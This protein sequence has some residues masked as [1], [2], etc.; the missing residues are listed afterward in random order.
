MRHQCRSNI[1]PSKARLYRLETGLS[2]D[3]TPYR[4]HVGLVGADGALAERLEPRT[5]RRLPVM[6]VS[7]HGLGDF[8]LERDPR[9]GL[10]R[11]DAILLS[12][13]AGGRPRLEAG[14]PAASIACPPAPVATAGSGQGDGSGSCLLR[15]SGIASK[16]ALP[17][18][19]LSGCR[20]EGLRGISRLKGPL[21]RGP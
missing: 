6:A 5:S 2:G 16:A 12:A 10:I 13:T 4:P 1:L 21:T 11:S 18:G 15:L 19:T 7:G 9:I 8:I 14:D 17:S 3:K 20:N